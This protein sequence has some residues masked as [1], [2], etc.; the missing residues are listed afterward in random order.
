MW[1][2]QFSSEWKMQCQRDV[3]SGIGKQTHRS[4]IKSV[5]CFRATNLFSLFCLFSFPFFRFQSDL[6][7]FNDDFE[8]ANIELKKVFSV[9]VCAR[10]INL[11]RIWEAKPDKKSIFVSKIKTSSISQSVD[12]MFHSILKFKWQKIKTNEI[13]PHQIYRQAD[14][15]TLVFKR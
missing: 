7:W 13:R 6:K 15:V 9:C 8:L 1:T 10:A 12:W 2:I 11:R 5:F 4:S 3:K 14:F